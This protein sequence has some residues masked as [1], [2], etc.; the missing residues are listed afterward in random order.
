MKF[1]SLSRNCLPCKRLAYISFA[2]W[3]HKNVLPWP[4]SVPPMDHFKMTNTWYNYH[5]QQLE[6]VGHLM[7]DASGDKHYSLPF[8]APYCRFRRQWK[9]PVQL[10]K[11]NSQLNRMRTAPFT[12]RVVIVRSAL[13]VT[14][15][16]TLVQNTRTHRL[17]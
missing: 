12:G 4:Y 2:L 5:N 8:Y 9:S 3:I 7:H 13:D 1:E 16:V 17:L 6:D 11:A 15:T 14:A 10:G